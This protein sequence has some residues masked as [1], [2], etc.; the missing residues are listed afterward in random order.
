MIAN[1]FDSD[2]DEMRSAAADLVAGLM[3]VFV[4]VKWLRALVDGTRPAVS[5]GTKGTVIDNVAKRIVEKP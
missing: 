2:G 3:A 4:I 5:D 1:T